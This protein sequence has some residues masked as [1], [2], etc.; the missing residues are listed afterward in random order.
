MANVLVIT[1]NQSGRPVSATINGNDVGALVGVSQSL[2]SGRLRGSLTL[3]FDTVTIQ[4]AAAVPAPTLAAT[5]TAGAT[6]GACDVAVTGTSGSIS[7][8]VTDAAAAT[9]NVGDTVSGL[10]AATGTS[11][12]ITIEANKYLNLYELSSGTVV[13]FLSH[14]V[15]A[16]EIGTGTSG[17]PSAGVGGTSARVGAMKVGKV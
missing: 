13:S 10:T 7:Y 14:Q 16:G 6:E 3:D 12:T 2:Q 4:A 5:F 1:V 15:V 11:F 8:S 17:D 9:P